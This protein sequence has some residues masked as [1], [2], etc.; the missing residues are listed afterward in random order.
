MPLLGLLLAAFGL[1]GCQ[2]SATT[3]A[4]PVVGG[5]SAVKLPLP[6]P[7]ADGSY[8][9]TTDELYECYR[10]DKS[11]ASRFLEGKTVVVDGTV[12]DERTN[13]EIDKEAAKRGEPTDPELVLYVAHKSNGF[14][15]SPTAIVCQFPENDRL[16]LRRLLKQIRTFDDVTKEDRIVVRGVIARKFGDVILEGCSLEGVI[17]WDGKP[18]P[19]TAWLTANRAA[20]KAATPT[21]AK[22]K[23]ADK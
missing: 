2:D 10:V 7:S 22:K 12:F 1:C 16:L 3:P 20:G 17:T 18:A 15:T 14:W 21:T 13:L 11:A 9:L 4:T 19:A 23:A 8:R 6:A 5:A